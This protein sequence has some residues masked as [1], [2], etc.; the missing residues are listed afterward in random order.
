MKLTTAQLNKI[1]AILKKYS[2]KLQV[3]V[4]ELIEQ[5]THDQ[6]KVLLGGVLSARTKDET[7]AKACGK[8]F[9]KI[10]KPGDFEK[11][12]IK[13]IEK[14]IYPVGF[15]KTKARNLKKLGKQLTEEFNS[16][17]PNTLKE[18][19][20]LPGAGR[21]TANLVLA[22]AFKKQAICVDTH[23]HKIM[24]RMGYVKTKNPFETEKELMQKLPKKLW[25]KTNYLFV[26]FGQNL[27]VPISPFCSKCPIEKYCK[28]INVKKSR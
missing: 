2:K 24:N 28:R 20:L 11:Y 12:S 6:F 23:V 18:L 21:K 25:R 26:A 17:I 4:A 1:Y 13:E 7:T 14:L 3:P 15:Y 19:I 10:K 8:L 27:C 5:E 16:K 22:V 9:K